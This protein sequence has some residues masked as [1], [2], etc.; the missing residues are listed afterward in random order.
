[1]E[2][3]QPMAC[4]HQCDVPRT[5]SDCSRLAATAITSRMRPSMCTSPSTMALPSVPICPAARLAMADMVWKCSTTCASAGPARWPDGR[6]T[7]TG[8]GRDASRASMELSTCVMAFIF[9]SKAHCVNRSLGCAWRGMAP[10]H[11]R[12]KSGD[13]LPVVAPRLIRHRSKHLLEGRL[14]PCD[15]PQGCHGA[16]FAKPM[17]GV[18]HEQQLGLHRE[19]ARTAFVLVGAVGHPPA[20]NA[21]PIQLHRAPH[22]HACRAKH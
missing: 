7:A 12:G 10:R 17:T 4:P 6:I 20:A 14:V 13:Q 18:L 3:M 16:R 22:T 11:S 1:M 2:R 19:G 5:G 9:D 15:Q 8:T 21:T